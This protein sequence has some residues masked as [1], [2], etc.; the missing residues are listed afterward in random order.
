M[1]SMS[2][3]TI[4]PEGI[5]DSEQQR[6][7]AKQYQDKGW[8]T[9]FPMQEGQKF[10]PLSGVTGNIPEE[11][12]REV[13]GNA[14]STAQAGANLG[15]RMPPNVIGID[16]DHYPEEGKEGAETLKALE[17][18]LGELPKPFRSTRRGVDSP[19]AHYFF[20]VE[21]GRK[22]H[23]KAG[24]DI[25]VLQMTHRYAVA[26]PSTVD[27]KQYQW[28]NDKNQE[29][30]IPEV[31]ELPPLPAAWVE[32]LRKGTL[33][34]K[35]APAQDMG[36]LESAQWLA[37][38]TP[39]YAGELGPI[40]KKVIEDDEGHELHSA[41][42][43][44]GHDTLTDKQH[45]AVQLAVLEGQS[46]LKKALELLAALFRGTTAE[47]RSA[48][49]QDAEVARAL[50]GAVN[51]LR[52]EVESGNVV[53][54]VAKYA[55]PDLAQ[56]VTSLKGADK[57]AETHT[58]LREK[59][60]RIIRKLPAVAVSELVALLCTE[61]V[62]IRVSEDSDVIMNMEEGGA[63][64]P[65]DMRQILNDKIMP[66]ISRYRARF[67]QGS[68][69]ENAAGAVFG[70]A[71]ALYRAGGLTSMFENTANAI[72]DTGR[73][74]SASKLNSNPWLIGIGD[75]VLDLQ[76]VERNPEGGFSAWLRP[77]EYDDA[78]TKSIPPI[79]ISGGLES[80]KHREQSPGAGSTI[81]E[82]LIETIHPD[83]AARRFVQKALGYSMF[84]QN[85]KHKFFVWYGSGGSGKGSLF[86]CVMATLGEDYVSELTPEQFK[87]GSASKPDPDYAA[88][89]GTR[90][91]FVN[92]TEE[93]MQIDAAAIKRGTEVRTGREL[94]SNKV[95]KYDGN[96]IAVMT[97]RPFVFN[98]DS[99]V[100]RRLAVIPFNQRRKV[101]RAAQPGEQ[102]PWRDRDEEKVWFFRWLLEG[103]ALAMSEGLETEDYPPAI[104]K[105]TREFIE[106]ADPSARFFN[107]LE[108][109]GDPEDFAISSELATK[110]REITGETVTEVSE[111]AISMKISRWFKDQGRAGDKG[112]KDNA[113]GYSGW[114][115]NEEGQPLMLKIAG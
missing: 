69:E 2:H 1:S 115:L 5:L 6:S 66:E 29:V 91:T 27:G 83:V 102:V 60:G 44:N 103:F 70:E 76:E 17:T 101:I 21:D 58:K 10:P 23:N 82:K 64:Q 74:F 18:E 55:D 110:Y 85:K 7:V 72:R 36:E 54:L 71:Y 40:F 111:R 49:S 86:D 28:F 53:P 98:H 94:Y 24:E 59:V 16:V 93:G 37:T 79:D 105:A 14:W 34:L 13:A 9:P 61:L 100:A 39:D 12:G 33:S 11:V 84:G 114:F 88:S 47:R 68:D 4:P 35:N 81:T 75:E 89:L 22:W 112:K 99:G 45:W 52:G 62:T 95:V 107:L 31:S 104:A 113:N 108:H 19:S 65:G 30:E 20:R 32:H 51:K 38:V 46:G 56:A 92:E 26:F 67:E 50:N 87:K 57:V 25:D 42:L 106:E 96:T 97:N 78:V 77:A 90:M 15:L 3:H 73:V 8:N 48:D 41:F 63:L 80:L 43:N 109:T